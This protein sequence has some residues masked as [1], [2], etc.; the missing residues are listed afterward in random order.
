MIWPPFHPQ[1]PCCLRTGN[2]PEMSRVKGTEVKV[3][4]D[5]YETILDNLYDGVYFVDRDG[6]ITF[7]NRGAERISGFGSAEVMGSRC[8]DNLLMHVDGQGNALCTGGSCPLR[9][10]IADGA[11][12]EAELYLHH[13]EGHR[14]PVLIRVAPLYGPDGQ[15]V[16]A[17]ETFSDNSSRVAALR[18][19]AKLEEMAYVDAL[20]GLANRR[21]SEIALQARLD[22]VHR[23]G[24][25]L[26]VLLM[27]IDH[28]KKVNDTWGHDFGDRVLRMVSQTLRNASR[29]FDIVGRWGGEEFISVAPNLSRGELH[30]FA[31]RFRVLVQQ[32]SLPAGSEM[33]RVTVSV[34]A[35]L[36]RSGDTVSTLV[37]RAD[38]LMYESK[39]SGRN[40]VSMD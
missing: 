12:R 1:L 28:F 15:I 38:R 19:I 7:W 4:D 5:F 33:V 36:A 9:K 13:K 20:T 30:S 23:Y 8:S 34:G 31:D 26:G 18:R 10:T 17:V 24:W 39:S 37:E 22:E 11:P 16:G 35:T 2:R 40:R 27:D 25:P 3:R 14:L 6:K 21:F 29:T 32:S